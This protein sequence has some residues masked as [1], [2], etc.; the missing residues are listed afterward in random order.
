[1]LYNIKLLFKIVNRILENIF[2][3]LIDKTIYY[4]FSYLEI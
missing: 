3:D 1:M 2:E 4:L